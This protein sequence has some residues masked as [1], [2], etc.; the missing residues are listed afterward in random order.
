MKATEPF[1]EVIQSYL[2]CRAATDELF[3]PNLTKPGKSIDDCCTYIMNTV[4][5]S[6]CNG[7][8]DDEIFS[9]AVHYFD[10][11]VIE[12]G[13]PITGQVVVNHTITLTD[14]EKAQAKEMAM[15]Q[16]VNEQLQHL[17]AKPKPAVVKEDVVIGDQ[18]SMF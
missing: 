8:S 15:K 16:A 13:K 18:I 11:D 1:K 12:I 4:K 2:A 17:K 3:A 10:E 7:F 14:S 5:A 9:M 6:G